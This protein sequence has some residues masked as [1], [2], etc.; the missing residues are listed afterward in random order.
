MK[1]EDKEGV[2]QTGFTPSKIFCLWCSSL[3]KFQ[4]NEEGLDVY[5][6][7]S[8]KMKRRVK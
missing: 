8:C 5:K 2:K 3:M 4:K 7:P 6:C 1:R